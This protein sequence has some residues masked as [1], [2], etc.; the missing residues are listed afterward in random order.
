MARYHAPA[1]ALSAGTIITNTL[2]MVARAGA[3]RMLQR[4]LEDEVQGFLG[5]DRYAPGSRATGYRNGH[6]RSRPE[7]VIRD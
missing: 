2:E 6:G 3:Q 5:R 1:P 4:A 7:R